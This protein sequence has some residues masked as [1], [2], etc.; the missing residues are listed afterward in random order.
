M[1]IDDLSYINTLKVNNYY[2]VT[3]DYSRLI[4]KQIPMSFTRIVTLNL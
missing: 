1:L 4:N 3:R 2:N